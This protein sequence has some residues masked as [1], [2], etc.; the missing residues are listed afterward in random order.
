MSSR[1]NSKSIH[2]LLN[3]QKPHPPHEVPVSKKNLHYFEIFYCILYELLFSKKLKC[4][5]NHTGYTVPEIWH[6]MDVIVIFHFG[7]FFALA[8]LPASS[9]KSTKNQ[10]SKK[11]KKRLEISSFYTGVPKIMMK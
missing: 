7:L 3:Q 9:P 2:P 11:M 4:R 5:E 8:L 10:F 1:S 6:V